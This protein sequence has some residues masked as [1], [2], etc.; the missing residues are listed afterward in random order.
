MARTAGSEQF[1]GLAI[2]Q[3]PYETQCSPNVASEATDTEP[4]AVSRVIPRS[5]DVT[6]ENLTAARFGIPP[7]N[8]SFN[9]TLGIAVVPGNALAASPLAAIWYRSLTVR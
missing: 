6:W 1:V 5:D 9:S 8:E 7:L 4:F 3:I 2:S